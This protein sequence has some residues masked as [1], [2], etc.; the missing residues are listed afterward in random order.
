LKACS[1]ENMHL[2]NSTSALN[3][4]DSYIFDLRFTGEAKKSYSVS[5]RGVRIVGSL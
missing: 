4:A 5:R 2:K 3:V 1:G